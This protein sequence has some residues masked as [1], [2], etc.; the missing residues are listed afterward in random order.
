MSLLPGTGRRRAGQRPGGC[1]A[2][3]RAG[4]G[5]PGTAGAAGSVSPCRGRGSA[6]REPTNH[7]PRD[8]QGLRYLDAL[9]SGDLET[10]AALWE[11]ASRDPELERMLAELDGALFVENAGANG[12][13]DA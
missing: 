2:R 12:R 5:V 7:L 4:A 11:E 9:D 1:H 8:L 13:A 3:G 10:V 6:M